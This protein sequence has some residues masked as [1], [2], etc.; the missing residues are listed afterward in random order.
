VNLIWA[1]RGKHKDSAESQRR[2][3]ATSPAKIL[4]AD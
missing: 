2:C 1:F 4:D 3:V